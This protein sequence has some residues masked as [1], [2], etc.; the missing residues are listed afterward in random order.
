MKKKHELILPTTN[1]NRRP[2]SSRSNDRHIKDISTAL[3]LT[4]TD[5]EHADT[6]NEDARTAHEE[7][8]TTHEDTRMDH[9]S[10]NLIPVPDTYRPKLKRIKTM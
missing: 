5:L 9:E 8:R 7:T 10:S 1:S 2:K 6:A 3:K 4:S